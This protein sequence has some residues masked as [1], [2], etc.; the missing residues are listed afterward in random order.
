MEGNP[1]RP[2]PGE[3]EAEDQKSRRKKELE[4]REARERVVK[5]PENL[6]FL[7]VESEPE[8]PSL[9]ARAWAETKGGPEDGQEAPSRPDDEEDPGP[10]DIPPVVPPVETMRPAPEDDEEAPLPP[11]E[12]AVEAIPTPVEDTVER[13]PDSDASDED[14]PP[15]TIEIP[16]EPVRIPEAEPAA[17]RVEA[18][19]DEDLGEPEPPAAPES[20]P[21]AA[22]ATTQEREAEAVVEPELPEAAEAAI[23]PRVEAETDHDNNETTG[24]DEEELRIDHARQT[25]APAPIEHAAEEQAV[26]DDEAAAASVHDVEPETEAAPV[27][28]RAEEA[29]GPDAEE[30]LPV[31]PEGPEPER[32][33]PEPAEA[34]PFEFVEGGHDEDEPSIAPEQAAEEEPVSEEPKAPEHIGHTLMNN[35]AVPGADNRGRLSPAEAA[36]VPETSRSSMAAES[37]MNVESAPKGPLAG[38]RIETLN[39]TELMDIARNVDID[40]NNL[41]QIYETHLIGERGLRRLIIEYQKGGDL[42]EALKREVMEREMDFERDPAMRNLAPSSVTQS[43]D[44]SVDADNSTLEQLLKE[45]NADADGAADSEEKAAFEE[46]RT[47]YEAAS[48]R[49]RQRYRVIADAGFFLVIVILFLLVVIVYLRR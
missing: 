2:L 11:A 46:A 30:E 31:T 24:E 25:E 4:E 3:G 32:P 7:A 9:V 33:E 13:A 19:D 27:A 26:S 14:E 40:G 6:G 5:K 47:K 34:R 38:I 49:G 16:A 36:V 42:G 28:P 43:D 45:A 17:A 20:E 22:P 18:Q 48:G 15:A 10:A 23:E 44:K 37:R 21:E 8:K 41:L 29:P 35:E 12:E 1:L 39:R